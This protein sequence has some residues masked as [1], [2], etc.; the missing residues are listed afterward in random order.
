MTSGQEARLSHCIT[1]MHLRK[2]R[3]KAGG[4]GESRSMVMFLMTSERRRSLIPPCREAL[5]DSKAES[6][7]AASIRT[8]KYSPSSIRMSRTSERRRS[9][10]DLKCSMDSRAISLNR[11]LCRYRNSLIDPCWW[12]SGAP[13]AKPCPTGVLGDFHQMR[14]CDPVAVTLGAN[15][16]H[17]NAL[18]SVIN[19]VRSSGSI[20]ARRRRISSRD[21]PVP[22]APFLL[23]PLQSSS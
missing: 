4:C 20:S 17:P 23:S 10:G 7:L 11:Q 6:D 9:V 5:L 12:S 22:F 16:Y 8:S 15:P 3:R 18:R 2:T 21:L 13:A 14:R 1:S 19:A